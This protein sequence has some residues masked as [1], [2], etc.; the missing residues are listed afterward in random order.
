MK[1]RFLFCLL[2]GSLVTAWLV[3]RDAAAA[4][5]KNPALDRVDF[6]RDIRPILSDNCFACHGPDEGQRQA[7]LRLDT[8]EGAFADRGG[9]QVI[10]A[11]DAAASRL[12][13]RISHGQE[14]ARMPP[15]GFERRP[16][17]RTSTGEACTRFGSARYR[18]RRWPPSML[19]TAKSAPPVGRAPTR[20]C[21]RS[22]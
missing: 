17:A 1:G 16:P 6:S 18:R 15:P 7:R 8:K 3:T 9:Y 14:I 11:R 10:V 13:Q 2:L 5:S 20:R 22:C 12:Y 21:R 4:A 19:R